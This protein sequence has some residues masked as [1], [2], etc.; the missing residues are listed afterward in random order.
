MKCAG[1]LTCLSKI[2]I[3]LLQILSCFSKTRKSVNMLTSANKNNTYF[4][5]A[6]SSPSEFQATESPLKMMKNVFYFQL[7]VLFVPKY[8]NSSHDVLL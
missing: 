6:P 7:K 3:D 1:E 4:E 2:N 8:L 5:G